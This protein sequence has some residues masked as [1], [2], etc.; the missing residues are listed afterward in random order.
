[1]GRNTAML[2]TA[3]PGRS[4]PGSAAWFREQLDALGIGNS[5]L[6]R[7]MITS[8]DDCQF[9]IIVRGLRRMATGESRIS[10]ERP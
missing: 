4:T 6:A 5:A 1:M 7:T 9:D 8:G 10:G 3:T 2:Q